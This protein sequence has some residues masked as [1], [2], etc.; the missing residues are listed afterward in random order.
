[1]AQVTALLSFFV[2]AQVALAKLMA[3]LL[4]PRSTPIAGERALAGA[5]RIVV[6]RMDELG[7]V[8]LSSAFARELR[9]ACPAARITWVVQPPFVDLLSQSP[10]S[11]EVIGHDVRCAAPLRP[12]LLPLRAAILGYR[13]LRPRA[14]DIVI[15]PRWDG[16]YWYATFAALF[17]GAPERVAFTER[18]TEHKQRVN[19]GY[20]SLL[21]RVVDGPPLEHEVERSLSLL[22]ALGVAVERDS[23]DITFNG[24]DTAS[25]AALLRERGVE[26]GERLAV[27]CPS[28]GHSPLKQWPVEGFAAVAVAMQQ[29]YGLRAV[30]VGAEAD[31]P[32]SRQLNAIIGGSAVDLTGRTSLPQLASLLA[33]ST[34]F[35]GADTGVL[36]L[37]TAVGCR[38]LGIFG[39]TN[40]ARFAP[41]HGNVVSLDLPCSPIHRDPGLDR[42]RKCVLGSPRCML[43]LS[44]TLVLEA[45]GGVLGERVREAQGASGSPV[46]SR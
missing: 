35:V 4:L 45:V 25:I 6:M 32:L 18:A 24:D 43:D 30:L 16:D 46:A 3:R 7:D 13:V 5:R 40:V 17:S 41:H 33:Q 36:H 1:M 28:F 20:D 22:S 27:L 12:L 42:C 19:A 38:V 29:R 44:P 21:T 11:D 14:P 15:A 2:R 34:L 23:L 10:H 8:V 31:V 26:S 9:R 37:A 39:P